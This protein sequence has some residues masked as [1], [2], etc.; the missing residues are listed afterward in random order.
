MSPQIMTV[1]GPVDSS[2]IGHTQPHEHLLCDLS[3]AS[4]GVQPPREELSATARSRMQTPIT[5]ENRYEIRKTILH[6]E[7]LQLTDE[8]TI[9]DELTDYRSAGGSAIVDATPI[10]LGRDPEGLARLSRRS[11]VHIVMGAGYYSKGFH[12]PFVAAAAEDEITRRI[13]EDIV[14]GADG[15]PV[16]SGVIGE[17]GLG[18]PTDP[19][20]LK[21]LRAASRAQMQTGTPLLIHP[22]GSANAPATAVTESMTVGVRPDRIVMAHLDARFFEERSFLD[23]AELGTYLELDLFGRESSHS[24]MAADPRW[25]NDAR[26]LYYVRKLIE[27]GHIE[28]ILISQDTAQKSDLRRFGGPGYGHIIKNVVP[29]MVRLG[30]SYEEI[31]C[32]TIENPRRALSIP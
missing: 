30:F 24:S 16:K 7:N 20:E 26:R 19:D 9:A 4:L 8:I 10:G 32:I 28:R 17:I 2:L 22:G 15:T 14:I 12:T 23:F 18:W 5:L 3:S 29:L 21:V 27:A 25:P 11:G 31:E 6:N 1:L 13:V